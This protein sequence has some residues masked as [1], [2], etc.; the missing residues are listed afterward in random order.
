MKLFT[1]F[2]LCIIT[3]SVGMFFFALKHEFILIRL[4]GSH[5]GLL[6][7]TAPANNK[8]KVILFARTGDTWR[9][10]QQ[11]LIWTNDVAEN[12]RLLTM[13][14]LAFNQEEHVAEKNVT[15]Q[16]CA[17]STSE[18][19]IYIS[20]DRNPLP[21]EQSIMA[22]WSLI[23]S[24]LKTIRENKIPLTNIHFLINHQPLQDQHLSFDLSWPVNGFFE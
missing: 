12:M 17:L 24:L 4:P 15:V 21:K 19:E 1:T 9:T 18:Q 3:A 16:S 10:E 8:K 22:K 6:Q 2:F 11:E 13:N 14:W 5:N 23:E 7:S 20:F